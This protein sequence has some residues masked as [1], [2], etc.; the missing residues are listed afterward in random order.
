[1]SCIR[2]KA[3]DALIEICTPSLLFNANFEAKLTWNLPLFIEMRYFFGPYPRRLLFHPFILIYWRHGPFFR[4]WRL[5]FH[6]FSNSSYNSFYLSLQGGRRVRDGWRERRDDGRERRLLHA[7]EGL[8][9][10]DH[11]RQGHNTLY[12]SIRVSL[13]LIVG[14]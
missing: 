10:Q 1:M 3:T 5:L 2:S 11:P 14:N 13:N 4:K 8:A 9:A 7:Q 6:P 12:M